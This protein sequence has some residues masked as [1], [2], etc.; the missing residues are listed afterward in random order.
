MKLISAFATLILLVSVLGQQEPQMEEPE[1]PILDKP[2]RIRMPNLKALWRSNDFVRRIT[3]ETYL[4][5]IVEG[6]PD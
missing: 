1:Q 2:E 3:A 6:D 4:S 5:D